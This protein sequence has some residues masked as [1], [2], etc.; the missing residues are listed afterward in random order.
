MAQIIH[1]AGE[2]SVYQVEGASVDVSIVPSVTAYMQF[3][4][5]EDAVTWNV[6]VPGAVYTE[7]ISKTFTAP[8]LGA[9]VKCEVYGGIGE[10]SLSASGRTIPPLV[11]DSA[12]T[13]AAS[14]L[15]A[16]NTLTMTP[17]AFSGG[18]TPY[19]IT[20]RWQMNTGDKWEKVADGTTYTI[21]D[22]D[23]FYGAQVRA[24]STCTDS[25]S[26]WDVPD[27]TI[28]SS[29][30]SVTI[31]EEPVPDIVVT[32]KT[33]ISGTVKVGSTLTAIAPVWTGGGDE[34]SV[35]SFQWLNENGGLLET[36]T[37]YEVSDSQVGL[38]LL[39][40]ATISSPRQ[41]IASNSDLTI[42][43]PEPV[44][45]GLLS[46]EVNGIEYN[47]QEAPPVTVLMND[48]M[49]VLI[50]HSGNATPT[51]EW[52]CR[53]SGAQYTIENVKPDGSEVNITVEEERSLTFSCGIR[54]TDADDSPKSV[55]VQ[56]YAVNAV[57]DAVTI[58]PINVTV[59]G[60]LYT[61]QVSFAAGT[62]ITLVAIHE[63]SAYDEACGYKWRTMSGGGAMLGSNTG[64]ELTFNVGNF[65]ST[66][67]LY[68]DVTCGAADDTPQTYGPIYIQAG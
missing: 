18:T 23:Q 63:G 48:P 52:S 32:Q 5:S 61:D 45:I 35:S 67:N 54:D 30:A 25:S 46:V 1:H 56:L 33:G 62:V 37:A 39:C 68:V 3:W 36:G 24:Q 38:K 66:N 53:Q 50:E 60:Q 31:I 19:T 22:G 51:Y 7:P 15:W 41:N 34:S 44:Q 65:P 47:F 42:A 49:R 40:Q 14:D 4:T 58:G 2:S 57:R 10:V 8:E 59:N 20:N 6:L 27:N 16:G 17:A 43:V 9:Y 21:P 26:L 64:H 55:D 12:P 29:S 28:K 11:V 13:I